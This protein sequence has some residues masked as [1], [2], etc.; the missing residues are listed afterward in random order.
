MTHDIMALLRFQH[1]ISPL[2]SSFIYILLK[3]RAV[4][5]DLICINLNWSLPSIIGPP[6]SLPGILKTYLTNPLLRSKILNYP[7]SSVSLTS[8]RI[9]L[10]SLLAPLLNS[11]TFLSA[12][13]C[14]NWPFHL[15]SLSLQFILSSTEPWVPHSI[16]PSLSVS[17]KVSV[18]KK[19][20]KMCFGS[21]ILISLSLSLTMPLLILI[22]LHWSPWPLLNTQHASALGTLFCQ[23]F[24]LE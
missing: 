6:G 4:I 11:S 22:Q 14:N 20:P 8:V 12:T 17:V 16:M 3:S 9:P 2:D 1:L 23:F 10:L 21:Y 5:S 13:V 18:D 24:F 7:M 15:Y 19:V